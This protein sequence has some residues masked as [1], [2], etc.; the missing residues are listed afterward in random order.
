ME[1]SSLEDAVMRIPT[2][3]PL[4]HRLK[5]AFALFATLGAV[6]VSASA[7]AH[8]WG[9]RGPRVGVYI[10]GPAVI[11]GSAYYWSR[12]YPYYWGPPGYSYYYPPAYYPPV[13]AVP[14][15]PTQYV[16]KGDAPSA[17][18][19]LDPGYWYYCRNPAGYYPSVAQCAGGWEKVAPQPPSS[20]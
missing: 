19:S 11:A 16:E 9:V 5:I 8:G 3:M 1:P 15:A 12:P 18:P 14:P 20:Q 17:A 2:A 4:V 10:G 6:L 7:D 13:A